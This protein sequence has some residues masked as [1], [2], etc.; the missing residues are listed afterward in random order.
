MCRRLTLQACVFIFFRG[1][2]ICETK[3]QEELVMKFRTFFINTQSV[4]I[5]T[6]RWKVKM[7]IMCRVTQRKSWEKYCRRGD[8]A[9]YLNA[10]VIRRRAGTL[11][12]A[13]QVDSPSVRQ[14]EHVTTF[15]TPCPKEMRGST[16]PKAVVL[17]CVINGALTRWQVFE[18]ITT[19]TLPLHY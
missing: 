6:G 14:E 18:H 2:E 4:Q 11:S 5:P 15:R 12:G 10:S 17:T 16:A 9:S 13:F 8:G 1:M 3:K 19:F 7:E